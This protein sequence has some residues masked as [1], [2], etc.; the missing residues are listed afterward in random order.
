MH[1]QVLGD[2]YRDNANPCLARRQ[3]LALSRKQA[4]QLEVLDLRELVRDM[5]LLLRRLVDANVD[6]VIQTGEDA[7]LI[8]ADRGQIEQILLN[9]TVNAC[10]AMPEGGRLTLEVKNLAVPKGWRDQQV[11]LTPG[12]YVLLDTTKTGIFLRSGSL[13]RPMTKSIPFSCP[14]K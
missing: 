5:G 12:E 1:V 7:G 2:V 10:D 6:F 4:V 8:K 3:L 9:L 13:L 14:S 11:S